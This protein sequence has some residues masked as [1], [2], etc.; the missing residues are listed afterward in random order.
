MKSL[1]LVLVAAMIATAMVS[2]ASTNDSLSEPLPAEV[3]N[4]SPE[5][6]M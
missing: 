6:A 2:A 5:Q 1:K 4:L 3:L